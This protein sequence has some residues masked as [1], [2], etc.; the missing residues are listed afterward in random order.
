[1]GDIA[2]KNEIYIL[3]NVDRVSKVSVRRERCALLGQNNI[4]P[5]LEKQSMICLL[6][7]YVLVMCL[8]CI[9]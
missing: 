9:V 8:L 4:G 5:S 6:C 1:M 7:M 2:T 3:V